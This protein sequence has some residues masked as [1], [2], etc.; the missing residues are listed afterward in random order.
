MTTPFII[1]HLWQSSCFALLAGLLAFVLRKNSPKVRY[2]VWLSASLKFLIPFALLVSLGSVVPRPARQPVSVA[3]PV[4]PNTLVQIAEP[5]SPALTATVPAHAP[6]DWAPAAIG[7]VWALG[8]LAIMLARCRSW[9]GV[10]AAL[11]AGT[12]IELP[13][14]V[15]ALITPGAEEPGIVGFLRP[16]LVLP[17]QLLE[18]LNPGQL[19]A[20]LTHEL[21]HVR[22]RDNFLAAVHM[23]VE[24]IFWF[25]PLVWWIG[26]HM[27]EERELAC[28]EEVLRMGCEPADYVEGILKVCRFYTESPLPCISG[29]T[30]ADVKRRLRAIL[31]G[32]IAHELSAAKKM[33]LA[34]I[35]LAALAAPVLI[36]VLNAPAIRAQNASAA[37]PKFEVASIKPCQYR[38]EPGGMYP[39]RGNSSPGR[40]GTGCYPLLDDHG[41]GLIANAYV[42]NA[43]RFTPINGGPS[44]IHSAF[45]EINAKA[46]GNPS[47]RMM[48]VPMM[49]VLLEDRFQLKIHR[50][51]SEGP[52]YF[53]SVAR[54]GPKLHS[55]TEGSC[56]PYYSSDPPPTL[57][58]GQKYCG[59]NISAMSPPSVE[60]Q[61]ATLDEFSKLLRQVVDRPV[62]DK[63]GI[64]G[65]FDI[66]VE[67]SRE[68]T[69]MAGMPLMRDGVPA[70]A[71][72][73]TDAPLIFTALHEQLGLRLEE[74]K[75]PVE[76]FVIDHIE[77]STGN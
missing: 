44:W 18:H 52:V 25:H 65:R 68:G 39:P 49:R 23:V 34:T 2:W 33:T 64:T 21:C 66:R 73:P 76:M 58:P 37:T 32:S 24:A 77:R 28:D 40:L 59:S 29:V 36:G 70:P 62:I 22:R 50:Q 9:L 11:R 27:V 45:Y 61:G 55:F 46:E 4:F 19:G 10:R 15:R 12:P 3:A 41:M 67:F 72:D 71:S 74:A 6:L 30:G 26:S 1:N 8:F 13:I 14:P 16:V 5:F 48:M 63:T 75:G 7:V 60:L 31:A 35:G 47:V 51:T 54:G 43:D 17:A 53:L 20:I 38:Q 56:T 42:S 69:K 57:Q